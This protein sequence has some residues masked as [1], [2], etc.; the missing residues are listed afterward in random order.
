MNTPDEPPRAREQMAAALLGVL[1]ALALGL[2][3]WTSR[4]G[5]SEN[6]GY[7]MLD[8]PAAQAMAQ[9]MVLAEPAAWEPGDPA[10]IVVVA[11]PDRDRLRTRLI[12]DMLAG[13]VLVAEVTVAGDLDDAGRIA[14]DIGQALRA[15]VADSAPG[16]VVLFGFG[17]DAGGAAVLRVMAESPARA[18]GPVF[19]AGAS[20][21]AGCRTHTPFWDETG[22]WRTRAIL[23]GE[24]AWDNESDPPAGDLTA[25]ALACGLA[26]LPGT[27]PPA[28]AEPPLPLR[29]AR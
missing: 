29:A 7:R 8:V 26:L 24:A 14:E 1:L 9:P 6:V 17:W 11:G 23:A 3:I 5:A 12:A 21:G 22:A 2:V 27:P 20:L 28:A 25:I 15:L 4:A 16:Q 18:I 10:A 13:R 19:A